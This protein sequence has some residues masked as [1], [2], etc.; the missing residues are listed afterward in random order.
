MCMDATRQ[1][2]ATFR[3]QREFSEPLQ[4]PERTLEVWRLMQTRPPYLRLGRHVRYDVQDVLAW[5]RE[6]RHG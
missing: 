4:M 5:L 6:R 1:I 3:F 2:T